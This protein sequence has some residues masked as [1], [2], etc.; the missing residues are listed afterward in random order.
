[1]P[2]NFPFWQVFRFAAPALMAGNTGLLKHASKCSTVRTRDRRNPA[3]RRLRRRCF[4]DAS[5]WLRS[6]RGACRG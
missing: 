1:M 4:P 5:H 6:G 3:S 2:R